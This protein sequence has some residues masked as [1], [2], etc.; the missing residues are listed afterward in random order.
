M[1]KYKKLSGYKGIRKDIDNGRFLATKYINGKEYSKKFSS[2]K[3]A[4]IWRINFHPSVPQELVEKKA[5]MPLNVSMALKVQVKLN[6]EDLGYNFRDVWELFK[7]I[8][9]LSLEKSSQDYFL[10]SEAFFTPLMNFK[11]VEMT[12]HLIDRFIAKHKLNA[13]KT[14]SRRYNFN[15]DLKRL[16]VIFNWYRENYDALFVSPI[17]KRHKQAGIIRPLP[18]RNKKMA[19]QELLAFFNELPSFWR[20]FAEMQFYMGARVSEVAGLKIDCIDLQEREIRIQYVVVWSKAKKVDYIKDRPKNG[21]IS[22]AAMNSKLEEI[23]KRRLSKAQNGYLFHHEG[24][25]LCYREIQ[26]QYNKALKKAGLSDKYS[27]THIMRHSMGTIT[28]RVTGSMDMAQAVTRHKDI[29]IAQQ[30]AGLPTE[31]NKQAVNDVFEY[32]NDL[33]RKTAKNGTAIGVKFRLT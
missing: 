7:S 22:Y 3:Q 25:P 21:E 27:S 13:I 12:A 23:A 4:M 16:K 6:G 2:L 32:L 24:K 29:R 11:M 10:A 30:Y 20:D 33:E 17:L 8:H 19:P 26:Y 14:K 5:Q 18:K 15:G 31:A 9:L 1:S 28:R